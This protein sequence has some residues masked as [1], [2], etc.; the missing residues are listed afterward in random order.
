MAKHRAFRMMA[1]TGVAALTTGLVPLLDT[2]AA[3]AALVRQIRVGN[4]TSVYEGNQGSRVAQVP[5]TLSEPASA[6]VTVQYTIVSGS[7]SAGVDFNNRGGVPRTLTFNP[8]QVAKT[9]PVTVYADT[10]VEPNENLTVTLSN[11]TGGYMLN[12]SSGTAT[13]LNDDADLTN[14]VAIG[15]ASVVEGDAGQRTVTFTASLSQPANAAVAVDYRIVPQTATGNYG[16]GT[17]PA[18]TDIKD[19]RGATKT[20][21]FTP[22]SSTGLTPVDRTIKVTVYPDT[23]P[24]FHES[25][26][27]ELFNVIGPAKLAD[28]V[29]TAYIL[30]DDVTAL[31]SW[32]IGPLGDGTINS[33]LVPTAIYGGTNWSAI[34]AGADHTVA[35][36]TD[37]SL[38]AWGRNSDGQLGVGDTAERLAP[39]RVGSDHDWASVAASQQFTIA[40]KSNGT[41]W[42]WG[43]NDVFRLGGSAADI[44]VPTRVGNASNWTKVSAGG[45][46]VVATR[47]DGSL[48]A[49]GQ[50]GFGQLGQGPPDPVTVPTR[51]GSDLDW[52]TV[53]AGQFHTM[54]IK[55]D[56]SLWAWGANFQSKLGDGTDVSR[57]QPTRI[58]SDVDWATV[59]AGAD[60]TVATKTDRSLW[61][62][63]D[64]SYGQLGNGTN[65]T[66]RAPTR[67]G[68]S[69]WATIDAGFH[70][71]MGIK[72][73]GSLW[74]WGRNDFGQLGDGT[75]GFPNSRRVPTRIGTETNWAAVSAT[76]SRTVALQVTL[77][78]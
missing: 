58:G 2:P 9:V 13:I 70:H 47:S 25:F 74:A 56:G 51:I 6:P 28:S 36:G 44:L 71:T 76:Y 40:R 62:W 20:L 63:G 30:D 42:A 5:V 1:V 15:D 67:I 68:T 12:V 23:T 22:A 52:A 27:V 57:R 45:F 10:V 4:I 78:R 18:G 32:G 75:Q 37:G 43:I 7:A 60:H 19:D 48:W 29:G 33:R 69:V 38:W 64:N 46:H 55:T 73:D 53:S 49:W 14:R 41:L 16:S 66:L 8:G 54:A 21:R 35:I 50:N 34:D 77:S 24:E 26:R 39:V 17:R 61:A 72:T 11:P 59:S 31:T 65:T 3:E